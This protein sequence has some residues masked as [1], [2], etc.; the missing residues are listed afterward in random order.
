MNFDK[1]FFA[2]GTKCCDILNSSFKF[3]KIFLKG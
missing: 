1:P 2:S 3:N